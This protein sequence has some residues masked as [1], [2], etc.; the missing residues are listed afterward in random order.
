M[1]YAHKIKDEWH[2]I[3]RGETVAGLPHSVLFGKSFDDEQR[4]EK[5]VYP[6]TEVDEPTKH[7]QIDRISEFSF[8]DG[9]LTRTWTWEDDPEKK[10]AFELQQEKERIGNE[11][12]ER[13]QN[14]EYDGGTYPLSGQEDRPGLLAVGVQMAGLV[15]SGAI[16]VEL[17]ST[18][19]EFSDGQ[20]LVITPANV[21]Q[22]T[23]GVT[24]YVSRS[25]EI[26]KRQLDALASGQPV[27]TAKQI[28]DAIDAA[29][30]QA[31]AG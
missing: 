27:P 30:A 11:H 5:G 19:F 12:R 2:E 23:N 3:Q 9:V 16:P 18:P 4:A 8:A 6:I 25:F 24:L 15:A 22:I 31:A 28:N 1:K 21:Q 7:W 26:K 14:W 17:I 20:F 13:M 10:A 29:F